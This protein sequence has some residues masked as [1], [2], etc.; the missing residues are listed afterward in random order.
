MR[1]PRSLRPCRKAC[2]RLL[3]LVILLVLGPVLMLGACGGGGGPGADGSAQDL[4]TFALVPASVIPWPVTNPLDE[5]A[6]LT[7]LSADPPFGFEP[8][9]FPL[10]LGAG[11]TAPLPL[12]FTP[13]APGPVSGTLRLHLQGATTSRG[14]DQLVRATAEAVTFA[15]TPAVL[16]FGTV[17]VGLTE[18]RQVVLENRSAR[19][20]VTLS[21]LAF[22]SPAYELLGSGLPATLGPQDQV[23][24][25]VRFTPPGPIVADGTLLVGPTDLGGAVPVPLRA[26]SPGEGSEEVTDFGSVPFDGLGRTAQMSVLVPGDAISL[27][28]EAYGAGG[29]SFG[30]AELL[31]PGDTVYEN[32]QLTGNFVWNAGSP[33]FSAT[34]PNTDRADVQLVPGGGTYLFRIWRVNGAT[35]AVDVR[36]IVE[37]RPAATSGIGTLPLNIWLARGI[38]PTAATAASDA[39][40]Q[41]MIGRIRST[42]A[43]KGVALGDIDY[44]D[45]E[46]PAF[47]R[48][49]GDAEFRAMLRLTSAATEERLNLFFVVAIPFGNLGGGTIGGIAG[50][51]SGPKRA[52]TGLSG[53]MCAYSGASATV[54]GLV[55]AHEIAHYLGLYHT[56]EASGEHDFLDDTL[57]CPANGTNGTCTTEGANYLMHWFATGG[58]VLTATQGRVLRGHPLMEPGIPASAKPLL[59]LPPPPLTAGEWAELQALPRGFCGTIDPRTGR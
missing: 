11:A 54:L 22:P 35:E 53:V 55:A 51:I 3:S 18:Q 6:T 29:G 37:R 20:T 17:E 52:G 42:Y 48:I 44:Y 47:D 43:A 33:V 45:V 28:I 4:G 24:L 27:T 36:T 2:R 26:R 38:A 59:F 58:D 13:S 31:G 1:V 12:V 9:T 34:V 10:L 16:D 19:S 39:R 25:T 41:Q 21:D 7:L 30:L 32:L 56:V 15:A 50:T 46:D 49:D 40:L 14:I 5:A 23:T 8:G 57:D